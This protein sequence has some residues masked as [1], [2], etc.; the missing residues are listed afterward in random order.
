MI[1][2]FDFFETLLNTRSMDF[3][4][5]LYVFWENYYQDKCPFADMKKYGEDLFQVLLE[6]HRSGEE[7]PFVKVELPLFAKKFGG[8][9]VEMSAEEE[10]DFLMRCNEFE[11]DPEIERFLQKCSQ[12]NV[13]MYVLSNSG[14]RAEALMEVLN[15][16]GIGKYFLHLWS[17]ADFGKIKPSREFFELAI[18]TALQENPDE[19]RENIVFVGDIYDTDVVGA[20]NAGIK[21]AWLNKKNESDTN[22]W[23]TYNFTSA[24]QLMEILE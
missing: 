9:K 16:F 15:R 5:G 24:G 3:N 18:E 19:V 22:G 4:R 12:L 23:A 2:I 14:F 17:S 11:L 10:A 6:K 20:H 13:P 8:D 7:Y 21:P 1:L